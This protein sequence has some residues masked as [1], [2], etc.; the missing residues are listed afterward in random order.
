MLM[1]LFTLSYIYLL[2]VNLTSVAVDL[3]TN[4]QFTNNL[5]FTNSFLQLHYI[6]ALNICNNLLPHYKTLMFYDPHP[7]LVALL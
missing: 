4:Q 5:Q 6:T 7:L 3:Q 2:D 1:A